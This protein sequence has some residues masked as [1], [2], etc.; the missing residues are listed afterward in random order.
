MLVVYFTGLGWQHLSSVQTRLNDVQRQLISNSAEAATYLK[1]T[2]KMLA[3]SV[4]QTQPL[5]KTAHDISE[6]KEDKSYT[7]NLLQTPPVTTDQCN[8]FVAVARTTAKDSI[9]P[10][11]YCKH[12]VWA[13]WGG[14]LGNRIAAVSKMVSEAESESC[15]VSLQSDMLSGWD[16]PE[17]QWIN[18]K[19]QSITMDLKHNGSSYNNSMKNNTCRSLTGGEWFRSKNLHPPMCHIHLLRKYFDINLTHV[20]GKT[21]SSTDHVALHVRSGDIARGTWSKEETYSPSRVH[22]GYGLFPTAYY[23]SVIREIRARRGDALTFFVLCETMGN[24][25]CEYFEKLSILDQNV[26]MRV[27]QPLIDDV[28]LMLCA[29]EVA[30]SFG[31]FK[32]VFDLSPVAQI[33]HTFS[34][35]P[36][37]S[38]ESC[39]M[40]SHWIASSQQAANF[41]NVTKVWKNSGFQR[42]E[43]DVAYDM[44]HTEVKSKSNCVKLIK[45]KDKS[46]T[47]LRRSGG[48]RLY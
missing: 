2:S 34:H 46:R 38:D 41:R 12:A 4:A 8:Y 9:V 24:P 42:H 7:K 37:H 18:E 27:K 17:T 28:R 11:W 25:T 19:H 5:P 32:H 40:V 45:A 3:A 16:P 43:V 44:H 29:S 14:R 33:R 15:G 48:K 6:M 26:V 21:C 39:S 36:R 22:P 30:M 35:T 10:D 31:T 20:L 13:L 1:L 23:I 47:E